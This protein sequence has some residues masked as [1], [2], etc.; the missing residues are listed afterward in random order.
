MTFG[1]HWDTALSAG[2][3]FTFD[4]E[5]CLLS[6]ICQHRQKSGLCLRLQLSF[7][8]SSWWQPAFQAS[9]CWRV[10]FCPQD[11]LLAILVLVSWAES[12]PEEPT[13][14]KLNRPLSQRTEHDNAM[15]F[16]FFFEGRFKMILMFF[17]LVTALLKYSHIPCNSPIVHLSSF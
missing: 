4:P 12:L 16:F 13:F 15:S 11:Y 6:D 5:W 17:F 7:S 9:L 10:S 8:V 14:R 1:Q 2:L 3:L